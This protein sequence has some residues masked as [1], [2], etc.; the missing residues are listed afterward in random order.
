MRRLCLTLLTFVLLAKTA[1]IAQSMGTGRPPGSVC[2]QEARHFD[3][4]KILKSTS[5]QCDSANFEL[6]RE[7]FLGSG[8]GK[9][10][11]FRQA[12]HYF[13]L[14]AEEKN[15]ASCAGQFCLAL[16][17]YRGEGVSADYAR[18]KSMLERAKQGS[19]NSASS[20]NEFVRLAWYLDDL[21]ETH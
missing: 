12:A 10:K 2:P 7:A 1:A 18:A 15:S 21:I 3:L 5:P 16:M 20:N 9:L 19:L 13:A 6:G 14:A 17:L 11:N 8:K 4:R